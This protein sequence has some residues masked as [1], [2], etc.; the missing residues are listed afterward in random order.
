[1]IKKIISVIAAIT[2]NSFLGF[3]YAQDGNENENTENEAV[4]DGED[5]ES[6]DDALVIPVDS[7]IAQKDSVDCDEI[8]DI[9]CLHVPEAME[10]SLDS[11]ISAYRKEYLKSDCITDSIGEVLDD[12][13]Y[14]ERLKA[15]PSIME[16]NYNSIVKRYIELYTVKKR[17]QVEYMLGLGKY[18]FPIFEDVLDAEQ[19]PIELKYL[20]VIESA[21]NPR[22][23]SRAGASGLWQ[24][25][26]STGK[27]YGL[28]GNS[29][30][31]E[32][33]DPL[34]A[35]HA[36]AK[37]LKN[38]YGIYGDW[39]L[40]IA[41]Y[42]C[43]PGNVNKAIRRSGGKRDYWAIYPFLPRETRGYVPAFIAATYTMTYYAEHKICPANIQ[44]PLATDTIH[45]TNRMSLQQIAAILGQDV[46]VLRNLNPQYRRDIIP[47]SK[48]YTV[49]LPSSAVNGFI[50]HQDTICNYKKEEL[51]PQ[52]IK[53]EPA[54]GKGYG[55]G[56]VTGGI[57][58]VRQ[59][60]TLGAIAKRNHVSVAQIKK[61]N[62]LRSD[63][64]S[65]GQRLRV[66]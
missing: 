45:T 17:K 40:V 44:F 16:M 21:L 53:V 4:S 62:G 30:V 3:I 15:I 42:N 61:W 60:D 49:C 5:G 50:E 23:F 32:R 14:I 35:T 10:I 28:D 66:R 37:Y 59:G 20:P 27:M 36:A 22:A 57:Y 12:S 31:D 1:M 39:S 51:C 56:P 25:M 11:L 65:I 41:A 33:R 2:F 9:A 6:D 19:M 64:L 43:G 8:K 13:V 63:K 38:L 52:R 34:K 55:Y 58:R 7:T 48:D 54:Y 46:E 24:F 18:Y 47:G 29:L 26:F